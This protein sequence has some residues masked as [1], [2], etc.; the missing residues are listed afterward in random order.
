VTSAVYVGRVMHS[1]LRPVRHRFAY[2]VFSVLLDLDEID[3]IARRTRVF[4]RNRFNLFAFHDR[5]HGPRD[6]SPLRPW[7]DGLLAGAGVTLDGGP[8]RLLC[9][10]RL[11]GYAFNPL[12]IWFCHGPGGDLRA[13]VYE[14]RNTFGEHHHYVAPLGPGGAGAPFRHG[15]DKRMYVSPFI[16]GSATYAFRISPPDERLTVLIREREGGEDTLVATYTGR[17]RPLT[18]ATLCAL[19]ITH[20]LMTLKVIAAIHWQ[21]LR[22]WARRLRVYRHEPARAGTVTVIR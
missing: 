9:F 14:V 6:G 11:L 18:G 3:G 21:A 22:L 20:P 19:A 17:R 13:I 1:R 4:S 2:R 7:I 5:D 15:C 8:V 10:P 16:S 12:S